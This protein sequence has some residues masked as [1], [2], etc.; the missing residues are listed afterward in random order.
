MHFVPEGMDAILAERVII[1]SITAQFF[2]GIDSHRSASRHHTRSSVL[3]VT[4]F[5]IHYHNP[6]HNP[7]RSKWS[8]RRVKIR[9]GLLASSARSAS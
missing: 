7:V 5:S 6:D 2:A 1:E 4:D 8:G 9:H 3:W